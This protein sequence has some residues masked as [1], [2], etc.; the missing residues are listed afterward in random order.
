MGHAARPVWSQF[1]LK[2]IKKRLAD[3]TGRVGLGVWFKQDTFK[4]WPG[5]PGLGCAWHGPLLMSTIG[6]LI[7]VFKV[8]LTIYV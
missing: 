1:F 7:I 2:K 5:G 3:Q 8:N 4:L 6:F